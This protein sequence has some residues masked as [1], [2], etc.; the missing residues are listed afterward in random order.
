ME[1]LLISPDHDTGPD[2]SFPWGVLSLGSYL[3]N[4]EGLAQGDVV[5]LDANTLT[6]YDFRRKLDR[7]IPHAKLIGIAGFTTDTPFMKETA[8][9]IKDVMPETP[10]IAG[11]PHA[12]QDPMNTAR[13]RNF[14]FVAFSYGEKT[15]AG[16]LKELDKRDPDFRQIPGLMYRDGD[17]IVRTE[18]PA[19][20]DFCDTNYDLLAASTQDH[21]HQHMQVLTGRGCPFRCT[22]CFNAIIEQKYLSRPVED[23]V[24]ELLDRE[25]RL[26]RLTDER[27]ALRAQSTSQVDAGRVR[28]ELLAL[29]GS[30]RR[31][32]LDEPL[33]ARP[34]LSKLLVGRVTF[35]PRHD[36]K[37]WELRGQG[38]LAGIFAAECFPE[39]M[40][41]PTGPE[42]NF[43]LLSLNEVVGWL[44]RLETLRKT[45][46]LA[47]A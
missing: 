17:G 13:Y 25:A 28:Q 8:D 38:T 14:D 37:R 43:S 29:A 31:V 5:L 7:L 20:V 24:T 18:A 4:V 40:A 34:I 2:S 39:G 11:G 6:R 3:T 32:L 33:H 15:L 26:V 16:L 9:H 42:L 27:E 47:V 30:W 22:F 21:F 19:P 10:I 35:T 1:L 36:P 46:R 23:L 44:Q 41:S 12:V 45:T